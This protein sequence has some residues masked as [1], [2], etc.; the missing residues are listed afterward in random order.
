MRPIACLGARSKWKG[1]A[2]TPQNSLAGRGV[3]RRLCRRSWV[4]LVIR[5]GRCREQN[6][7]ISF[8]SESRSEIHRLHS[9]SPQ[10]D[11][12]RAGKRENSS[13]RLSNIIYILY[14]SIYLYISLERERERGGGGGDGP[15]R[16]EDPKAETYGM[17]CQGPINYSTFQHNRS[18]KLQRECEV[19]A[20]LFTDR[21]HAM[22]ATGE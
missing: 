12:A 4:S 17:R 16:A 9:G 5:E 7:C 13:R 21:D 14:L 18:P 1:I 6:A 22:K 3:K 20:E 11:E 15:V 19:S 8:T 2:L 10:P